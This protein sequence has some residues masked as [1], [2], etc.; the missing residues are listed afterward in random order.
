M[1]PQILPFKRHVEQIERAE[2]QESDGDG[3][4]VDAA[5]QGAEQVAHRRLLARPHQIDADD[6]EKD[7]DAGKDHRRGQKLDLHR[8]ER[9]FDRV[10]K[11]RI[12][13]ALKQRRRDAQRRRRQDGAGVRFIKVGA[14]AGDVA[15]IVAHIVGD[16]G[17]V[18]RVVFRYARFDL[19]DDVRADICR[20]GVDA[21]ADAREER[22]CR[23]S[24][25]EAQ[26]DDRDL[27]KRVRVK[28][29]GQDRRES[30]VKY[31]EPA[32][33]VQQGE[34]DHHKAHHGARPKSDLQP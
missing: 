17:G 14:H 27:L 24:H 20:L 23:G 33:D 16:H 3:A 4:E 9:P 11:A 10:Q 28:E 2:R 32:G 29:I 25:A 13:L 31:E 34:T 15:H 5:R 8:H 18:A 22:L 21:A 12:G 1:A 30:I 26:H 7:A 19:A 6:R